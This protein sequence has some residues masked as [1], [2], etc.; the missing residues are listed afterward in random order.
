MNLITLLRVWYRRWRRKRASKKQK[1]P[2]R[3]F[4]YLDE[5]SVYSL[6]ASR[7]GPIASEFTETETVSLQDENGSSIGV[8]SA[9]AKAEVSSRALTSQTH[10]SQVLRRSTVQTTFKELY[11][12]EAELDSLAMRPISEDVKPPEVY[13]LEN[14]KAKGEELENDGWIVDPAKLARGQLLEVDVQLEAEAIFQFNAVISA[15]LEIVQDDP[16]TFGLDRNEQFDQVSSVNRILEKLLVSLVPIRGY[17]ADYQVVELEGR[18]WIVHCSLLNQG[19]TTGSLTIYPL[20]VVG[21]AEHSLFWRDIRRVLFSDARFRVLC[22]VAQGGLQ[23]SWSPVKLAHVLRSVAPDLADRIDTLG[24]GALAALVETSKPDRSTERKQQVMREALVAY[25]KALAGHYGHSISMRELTEVG[26]PSEQHCMSFGSLE[27]KRKAFDPIT[28]HLVDR[29]DLPQEPVIAA[30]CRGTALIDSG[31]LLP[32]W[33]MPP[34]A[35]DD[36]P[37]PASSQERILDSEFVATYW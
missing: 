5:V 4:V 22:R 30:Q 25:A 1:A 31:L 8:S 29:F 36:V 32:E 3:E 26:L 6:M 13:T 37:S 17:A 14:L 7:L 10:G 11:E 9:I 19:A 16:D 24:S 21:V 2:L 28:E 20:Y 33:V 15:V 23:N 34:V 12:L 27:E 35:S 18:E